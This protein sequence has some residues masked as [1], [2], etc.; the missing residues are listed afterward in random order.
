M[1]LVTAPEAGIEA[2]STQ[3]VHHGDALGQVNRVVERGDHARSAD[4]DPLSLRGDGRRDQR[5]VCETAVRREVVFSQPDLVVTEFFGPP[6]LL[7]H[8]GENLCVGEVIGLVAEDE[9]AEPHADTSV[10]EYSCSYCHYIA[11]W[12]R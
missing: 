10:Q 12:N 9:H 8:V 11:R 2:A 1:R 7:E 5:Q 3:V 6:R 4:P